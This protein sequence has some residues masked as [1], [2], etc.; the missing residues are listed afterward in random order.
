MLR[1][2]KTNLTKEDLIRPNI[3]LN[4]ADADMKSQNST[5]GGL[6]LPMQKQISDVL[7]Q[8]AKPVSDTWKKVGDPTAPAI[9]EVEAIRLMERQQAEAAQARAAAA[10]PIPAGG[11][12]MDAMPGAAVVTAPVSA[13]DHTRQ[14]Y[15]WMPKPTQTPARADDIPDIWSRPSPLDNLSIPTTVPAGVTPQPAMP[16]QVTE[17]PPT[18]QPEPMPPVAAASEPMAMPTEGVIYIPHDPSKII[19][20]SITIPS[21]TQ[22]EVNKG[23]FASGAAVSIPHDNNLAVLPYAGAKPAQ[24]YKA[25]MQP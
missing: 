9:R 4:Q 20:S 14:P 23:D 17:L 21:P 16:V 5:S 1:K 11:Q 25:A 19:K 7:T 12:V 15:A 3:D 13:D 2:L 18:P 22:P 10:P 8:T 24:Q 6:V